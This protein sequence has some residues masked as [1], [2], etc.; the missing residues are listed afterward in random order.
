V[1]ELCYTDDIKQIIFAYA[2]QV[3]K[4]FTGP[5][6]QQYAEALKQVRLP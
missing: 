4:G 1:A 5:K 6:A 3:A 2:E